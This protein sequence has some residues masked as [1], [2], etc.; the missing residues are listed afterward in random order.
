M[1]EMAKPVSLLRHDAELQTAYGEC[2]RI[3]R[4]NGE[5]N[6]PTF[7]VWDYIWRCLPDVMK[8]EEMI[9]AKRKTTSLDLKYLIID[10]LK[11]KLTPEIRSQLINDLRNEPKI[12]R[13]IHRP[14][15]ERGYRALGKARQMG[16]DVSPDTIPPR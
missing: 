9:I 1:L 15:S 10:I 16:I 12:N 13:Y 4:K 5:T 8:T 11:N 2:L 3:M 14:L 6:A 7:A